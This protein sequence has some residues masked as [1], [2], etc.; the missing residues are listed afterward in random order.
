M[1]KLT[2]GLMIIQMGEKDV[3]MP[4]KIRPMRICGPYIWS[5]I[6]K[7]GFFLTINPENICD[8]SNGG[9]GIILN[10]ASIILICVNIMSMVVNDPM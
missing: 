7:S 1:K 6:T 4:N 8:P 10:T 9:M 3:N 2:N 5:F